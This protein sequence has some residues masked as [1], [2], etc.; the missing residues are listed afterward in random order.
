[1][2]FILYSIDVK[3]PLIKYLKDTA[4]SVFRQLSRGGGFFILQGFRK[5][6][7]SQVHLIVMKECFFKFVS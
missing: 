1:M 5:K 2:F 3:A 6:Q 7:M 4:E